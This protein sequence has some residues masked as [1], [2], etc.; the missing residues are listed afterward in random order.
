MPRSLNVDGSRLTSRPS[1][2]VWSLATA[3]V[4]ATLVTV[5]WNEAV[6]VPPSSS[7]TPTVTVYRPLSA[8]EWEASRYPVVG[9]PADPAVP[10][11]TSPASVEVPSPQLMV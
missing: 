7:V 3:S 5:T 10:I 8:K 9:T 11:V 4:G 2:T 1:A 6:A